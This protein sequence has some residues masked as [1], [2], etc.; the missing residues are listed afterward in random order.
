VISNFE[1]LKFHFVIPFLK[2]YILGEENIGNYPKLNS[3]L[4]LKVN[5]D[6]CYYN[7][8]M[9]CSASNFAGDLKKD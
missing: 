1:Y 3:I 4:T 2:P 8:L 7:N 5:L 6:W 9:K